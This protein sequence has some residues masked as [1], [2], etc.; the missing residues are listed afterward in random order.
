MGA[1]CVAQP[2]PLTGT[3][4]DRAES[5]GGVVEE[6]SAKVPPRTGELDDAACHGDRLIPWDERLVA[7]RGCACHGDA[8]VLSVHCDLARGLI[9]CP[10]VVR[11]VAHGSIVE[12]SSAE[13]AGLRPR[14]R[15][16][17]RQRGRGAPAGE[18]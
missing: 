14:A 18:P 7:W 4:A 9:R 17:I 3:T 11:G 15:L 16:V 1:R 10:D 13:L 6:G 12:C 8:V 2:P 5:V